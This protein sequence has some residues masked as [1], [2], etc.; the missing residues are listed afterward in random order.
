MN[1]SRQ[2]LADAVTAR[3]R[4]THP[5]KGGQR[6]THLF[7]A[8]PNAFAFFLGQ[9]HVALGPTAVYEWDFEGRPGSTYS[10]GF[11]T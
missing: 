2:L 7:I 9:H 4:A 3:L 11:H 8:G 1:K 5:H 10:L 6:T